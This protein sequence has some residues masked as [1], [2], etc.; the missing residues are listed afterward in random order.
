MIAV[1][2]TAGT[3]SECQSYALIAQEET[4]IKMACGDPKAAPKLAL[5]DPE[6]TLTQPHAVT[7]AAGIDALAH[8]IET[9]VTRKRNA[10]SAMFAREAFRRCVRAFPTVLDTPD[11]LEARGD[12]ILGAAL[13]GLAIENSMLGAAHAAANPLTARFGVTHGQAVGLM[14]PA[15]IRFNA[16][17]RET[18]EI[19]SRLAADAGLVAPDCDAVDAAEELAEC[20]ERLL[21]LAGMARSLEELGIERPPLDDLARE[22]AR[23]WT[24]SFNPRCVDAADF[25]RL[26]EEVESDRASSKGAVR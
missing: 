5:L 24:A 21:E 22:A 26:Y 18:A 6:L 20:V 16:E 11:D 9:S 14:L 13:S 15:V 19:Y 3:G 10:I 4:H 12:M 23:Q 17:D 1:P 2:T 8:A 25:V 7:A